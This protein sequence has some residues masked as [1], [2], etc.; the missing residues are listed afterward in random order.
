MWNNSEK[1]I[2]QEG[3]IVA[4]V[5][6]E[7]IRQ[8][9]DNHGS[10]EVFVLFDNKKFTTNWYEEPP[11][12]F[13]FDLEEEDADYK[14]NISIGQQMGDYIIAGDCSYKNP[15]EEGGPYVP[16][17]IEIYIKRKA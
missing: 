16:I 7:K 10:Y 11:N 14:Y 15:P 1:K 9:V 3:N 6:V 5:E 13:I 4:F 12:I 2:R 17:P 8:I